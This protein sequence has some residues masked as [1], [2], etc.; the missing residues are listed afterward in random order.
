VWTGNFFCEGLTI[1]GNVFVGHGV[2]STDDSYPHSTTLE[3]EWKTEADWNVEPTLVK[4]W[5]SI[6]S[7]ETILPSLDHR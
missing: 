5:A 7:G 3:G 1:E 2:T 6:G 4:K